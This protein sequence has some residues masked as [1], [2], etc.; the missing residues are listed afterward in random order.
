MVCGI[1]VVG[2]VGDDQRAPGQHLHPSWKGNAAQT[3][4]HHVV[5][6]RAAQEGLNRSQSRRR[7]VSLAGTVHR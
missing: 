2:S 7:I 5:V 4:G 3:L 1:L 6:Q